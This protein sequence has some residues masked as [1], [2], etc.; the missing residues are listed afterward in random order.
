VGPEKEALPP[1]LICGPQ[2]SCFKTR[3]IP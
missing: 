3:T 2:P 1:S